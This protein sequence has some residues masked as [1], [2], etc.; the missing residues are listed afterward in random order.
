MDR[1]VRV[2]PESVAIVHIWL[3]GLARVRVGPLGSPYV[4]T[5]RRT[6]TLGHISTPS[7]SD[8]A[9]APLTSALERTLLRFGAAVRRVTRLRGLSDS[10]VDEVLQDVR[11]RLWK[12]KA[13]DEKLDGL[14]ASYI[15]RVAM[16]AAIDMLRRRRAR[17]EEPL[18]EVVGAPSLPA[19]LLVAS[20]DRSEEDELAYR[21][22]HALAQLPQNRQVVVQ[23][24]LEGY[25]RDDMARLTGWSEAKVRNL[26]YRGLDDLRAQLRASMVEAP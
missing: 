21:L 11:V 5:C 13:S 6:S 18:H 9:L 4:F 14:G 25:T 16:S 2:S 8:A 1:K 7:P 24:H 17:R 12:S 26:L 20:P 23:L 22:E 10:D 3:T 19:I 15:Q